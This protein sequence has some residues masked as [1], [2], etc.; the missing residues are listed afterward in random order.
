MLAGNEVRMKG[1][2]V[3]YAEMTLPE[4]EREMAVTRKV[5]E[6]VPEDRLDFKPCEKSNTIGWNANHLAEIPGWAANILTEPF[7]DMNPSGN[8]PYRSP[9]FRTRAEM[10]ALFDAN[11]AAAVRALKGFKDSSVGETWQFKETGKTLFE[12]PRAAAFRMW[13]ISHTI[14]HRAILTAYYRMVG[15]AVPAVYGPSGDEGM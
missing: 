8:E 7:F 9:T 1:V 3:M 14:H 15:V 6:R 13:V 10:L 2:G 12:M 4:F 11:V 5:L